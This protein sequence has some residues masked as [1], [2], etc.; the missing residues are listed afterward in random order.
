MNEAQTSKENAWL[1]DRSKA[2]SKNCASPKT[3]IVIDTDNGFS[4]LVIQ[5]I[6]KYQAITVQDGGQCGQKLD[7]GVP[8]VIHYLHEACNLERKGDE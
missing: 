8:Q 2:A 6:P 1:H 5:D 7:E 4:P 3:D